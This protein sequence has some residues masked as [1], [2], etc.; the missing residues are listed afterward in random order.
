MLY[1]R[2]EKIVEYLYS[3]GKAMMTEQ[4]V[5]ARAAQGD[6][7]RS[8]RSYDVLCLVGTYEM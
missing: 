5:A 4:R 8:G 2:E 6:L 7:A 1:V 3:V